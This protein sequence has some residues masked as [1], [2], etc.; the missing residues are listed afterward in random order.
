VPVPEGEDEAL[1]ARLPAAYLLIAV[2]AQAEARAQAAD[3]ARG[4]E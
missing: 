3:E 2:V 4:E 1:S